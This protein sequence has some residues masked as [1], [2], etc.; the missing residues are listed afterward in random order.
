MKYSFSVIYILFIALCLSAQAPHQLNYQAIIRKADGSLVSNQPVSIRINIISEKDSSKAVYSET[1]NTTTNKNGLVNLSIGNNPG[2]ENINWR[3]G[4]Y[5]IKT[6]TDPSGGSNYSISGTNPILSVP[7]ALYAHKAGNGFSGEYADLK[8]K[9]PVIF[10]SATPKEGDLLYFNGPEWTLLDKGS[11]GQI[12]TISSGKPQWKNTIEAMSNLPVDPNTKSGKTMVVFGTSIPAQRKSLKES[13]PELVGKALNMQVYNEAEGSSMVR[14]FNY[15]GKLK[16]MYW[17]PVIKSLSMT[18]AE[19]QSIIDHWSGGLDS[20]GNISPTGTLGWKDLL[21]GSPPTE[22]TSAYSL[23]T[24]YGFSYEK[25]IVA[26][27]LESNS[28]E[29]ICHPDYFVFDHGHNDLVAWTYD[30][31]GANNGDTNATAIPTPAN[32]RNRFCGAMNYLIDIIQSYNP[33]AKIVII[34]HYENDRKTRIFQAQQNLATYRNLPLLKTW[35]LS[36]FN[37]KTIQTTGKWIDATTWQ[38]N[39]GPNQTITNTKMWMYDDLHPASLPATQR[40][41]EI[42]IGFWKGM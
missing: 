1:V 40:L 20:E 11:E 2:F 36:G 25:K 22:I 23:S 24:I 34:G 17:E 30:Q 3:S 38:N 4:V 7:I 28:P 32:A 5:H 37:Q 6:E 16:G 10:T 31:D 35:D 21:L 14:A 18:I 8:N 19:K 42:W 15:Q 9:P 33:R 41:A 29:F 39:A 13:Y 26:K 27:Y 12:L